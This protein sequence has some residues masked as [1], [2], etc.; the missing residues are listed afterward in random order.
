VKAAKLDKMDVLAILVH[1]VRQ[2]REVQT[3]SQEPKDR[4]AIQAK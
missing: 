2:D 1:R 4:L 3:A